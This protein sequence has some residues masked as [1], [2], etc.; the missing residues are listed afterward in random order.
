LQQPQVLA[1]DFDAGFKDVEGLQEFAEASEEDL[2]AAS[3]AVAH[4]DRNALALLPATGFA[5]DPAGSER[6]AF[7]RPSASEQRAT[8]AARLAHLPAPPPRPLITHNAL[9]QGH[10]V[11]DQER[12]DYI[13]TPLRGHSR[14]QA[15]QAFDGRQP[16]VQILPPGSARRSVAVRRHEDMVV[17]S[18]DL[19]YLDEDEDEDA[20]ATDAAPPGA[21]MSLTPPDSPDR[22]SSGVRNRRKPPTTPG[23][24]PVA[25]LALSNL[26]ATE[27]RARAAL[28]K[29]A[30]HR[31]AEDIQALEEEM[32]RLTV[33]AF[34]P[35]DVRQELFRHLAFH[36]FYETGSI[37][38]SASE[39]QSHWWVVLSGT[40]AVCKP[41]DRGGGA[42]QLLTEGESFGFDCMFP[43]E[44][45]IV[46]TA[47]PMCQ[48]ASV[49]AERFRAAQAKGE[50]S[51]ARVEDDGKVVLVTEKRKA[52]TAEGKVVNVIVQGSAENLAAMLFERSDV[53]GR[54]QDPRFVSVFLL[55]YRTFTTP[56]D[57]MAALIRALNNTSTRARAVSVLQHWLTDYSD[58]FEA[59]DVLRSLGEAELA[60]LHLFA[61]D[62]HARDLMTGIRAA[63]LRY[64]QGSHWLHAVVTIASPV[65]FE[66]L[67]RR[68][69][70]TLVEGADIASIASLAQASESE[71][72][73]G[74]AAGSG[75]RPLKDADQMPIALYV[76]SI[77]P[78]GWATSAGLSVGMRLHEAPSESSTD[79]TGTE[80]GPG[81]TAQ[82]LL[83]RVNAGSGAAVIP[84]V[85]SY[86]NAPHDPYPILPLLLASLTK[87]KGMLRASQ[88]RK[89]IRRLTSPPPQ[90]YPPRRRN[91]IS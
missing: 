35:Q 6:A 26:A 72:G 20:L 83:A 25:P 49:T 1:L 86:K 58:D 17:L 14:P 75:L 7:R 60:M 81:W 80:A 76:A 8:G 30:A 23:P 62:R 45:D 42:G 28:E 29:P 31:Q 41:N 55:T 61:K 70:A 16:G 87:Q 50:A 88:R 52:D 77:D 10:I 91:T 90:T 15:M 66:Q 47:A 85:V 4:D 9:R 32:Q 40:V 51:T 33:F 68:L 22:P 19:D 34:Q 5:P 56:C 21:G 74:A 64:E 2:G 24:L 54:H 46:V 69:G 63:R 36:E 43:T 59:E 82:T 65:T 71:T 48:L 84:I 12:G 3:A 37:V 38:T 13:S 79:E 27:D 78:T 89:R 57:V 18:F 44:G 73:A 11:F 53:H 67:S 39:G